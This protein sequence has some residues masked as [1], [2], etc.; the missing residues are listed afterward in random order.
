MYKRIQADIEFVYIAFWWTYK[1]KG[2]D[3]ASG[4]K[5]KGLQADIAFARGL[6]AT[7]FV[8]VCYCIQ[9]DV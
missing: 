8:F 6:R 5:Y 3:N 9:I 2:V 4:W 1:G 7:E